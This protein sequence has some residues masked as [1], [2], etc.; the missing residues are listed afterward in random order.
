L[1]ARLNKES[2]NLRLFKQYGILI[3]FI[4]LCVFL[5]IKSDEFLT[6][7]NLTST[8]RSLSMLAIVT[9]GLTFCVITGEFDLSFGYIS[10]FSGLLTA[11]AL[12][13]G[14][15]ALTAVLIGLLMGIL[16]GAVNGLIVSNLKIN[17]FIATLA[18]G[19][20]IKGI[21]Y[22]YSKGS[23]IYIDRFTQANFLF[24]GQGYLVHIPFPIVILVVVLL[25]SYLVLYKTIIGR[26]M[27]AIGGNPLTSFLSG[28]NVK[29][30]KRI[31]FIVS[32]FLA[33][34]AG[35]IATSRV[36]VGHPAQGQEFTMDAFAAVF[37]GLMLR[38]GEANL[39]G[40]FLGVLIIAILNNGLTLLSVPF[41]Y[42]EIIKGCIILLAVA[43]NSVNIS[44][45]QN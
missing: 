3:I 8:M 28:I 18:T 40:S 33:A 7:R 37:I 2:G 25:V 30:Y 34:L 9:V 31:V 5:S 23:L 42:Q 12:Q 24:I 19:Y 6:L 41:F 44:K 13:A 32:G 1:K 15:G 45:E 43:A 4:L 11:A 38:R 27:Y 35:I 10:G 20:L 22:L 16:I 36:A 39:L 26:S 17:S 29:S 14:Y 21:T